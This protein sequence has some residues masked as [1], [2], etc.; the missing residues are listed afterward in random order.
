MRN[1][2]SANGVE[3]SLL[4]NYRL[5]QKI[6]EGGYGLVF[7]AEQ[8]STGQKVA[9]KM[10]KLANDVSDQ[11]KKQSF[12]R[13]ER[14]T[15]LCAE[16][17]HPHI[18][19]LLD[20]G[21]T[22]E[23]EPFAVFEYVEGITLKE[24][25]DERGGLAARETGELMGQVL[26]AI[27]AAHGKGIVHRDLKPH[28]I[29]VSQ[30][31]SSAHIKVLDF[32]IGAFT[33]EFRRNDYQSLTLTREVMGTPAYSAPEQLRGEPATVKS[34]LYAWGLI[35]LEC[36]TGEPVMSGDSVAEIFQ[37]QLHAS[38]VPL[39]PA[40][41]GHPLADLLRRVVMK[42]SRER[43]GE[44]MAI[45]K[46]FKGIN[47]STLVGKISKLGVVP[48][49]ENNVTAAYP[50]GWHDRRSEKRQITVLCIKLNLLQLESATLDM[51]TLDAIQKD[52]LN[53]CRDIG[54]RFGG[55][56]A[57]ALAD[58]VMVYFGYPQVSDN[59]ARRAGRTALEL[60]T[61]IRRR[62][63]LLRAQHGLELI[64]RMGMHSG[65]VLT[66]PNRSPEGRVPNTAL[67]LLYSA[68]PGTILISDASRKLLDPY[69]EFEE[70]DAISSAGFSIPPTC[71]TITGE[72]QTEAL[73][74]LRPWSANRE[75]IGRDRDKGNI[76][77][78]WETTCKGKGQAV[79]LHGQA[80]IGKSKMVYE[81]KKQVRNEGYLF[82]ECRCLPEH[83][84]NALYP[85]LEMLRN[86]WGIAE[87]KNETAMVSQLEAQLGQAG[88]NVEEGLPILCSWL[89]VPLGSNYAV[90]QATPDV[91][92][93]IL[94][95]LLRQ[96]ILH[97]GKTK[98][99]MLVLE[100]LHWL[101]PTGQEFVASLLQEMKD[102]SCLLLMTTR[103]TFVPEW[104]GKH[105]YNL[106]LETL[107]EASTKAMVE[108]VLEGKTIESAS[109][110][111]INK[112]ADGIPLYIEELTRMLADDG[113][114]ILK[115]GVYHLDENAE[116]EDIPMTLQ[117]LL[118][119]RLDRLG[120]TKE[121][122]QLAATMGREFN[123][124]LL[125][126][127]SLRDEALVQS[128]L[129]ALMNLDMVYRQRRVSDDV[130]VFR[131]ALIRDA[132]YEGMV[133]AVRK[134]HHLRVAETLE[135][136]FPKVV[137]DT[138]FELARHLA[139]GERFAEA[140]KFGIREVEKQVGKSANEEAIAMNGTLRE[141]VQKINNTS[142]MQ[143]RMVVLNTS[144][145]P[146]LMSNHGYA[147]DSIL[148]LN[149][150]SE[151]Y[152]EA[153]KN[154]NV[155][156]GHLADQTFRITYDAFTYH[157]NTGNR[158]K[159]AELRELL[160]DKLERNPDRKRKMGA[161]G[162][163]GQS[164]HLDGRIDEALK[165]HEWILLNYKEETDQNLAAEFGIDPKVCALM[166]RFQIGVSR[167]GP[168][169]SLKYALECYDHAHNNTSHDL[170]K[171]VSYTFLAIHHIY[172]GNYDEVAKLGKAYEKQFSN[173]G[174]KLWVNQHFEM[175]IKCAAR[176]LIF[177]EKYVE[178]MLSSGQKAF[179]SYFEPMLAKA[180]L[181]QAQPEKA[182]ELMRK[183][184]N[185]C[186]K[187]GENWTMPYLMLTLAKS[188]FV[189]QGEFSEEIKHILERA[190]AE[191]ER[192]KMDWWGL[193][194][195]L[196]IAECN[197]DRTSTEEIIRL[198][199][200]V[201]KV[202]EGFDTPT[203]LLANQLIS[204]PRLAAV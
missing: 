204:S 91:Q 8:L 35:T 171:D 10:L 52:Q 108:I 73:S 72:R 174:E 178:V 175:C 127:A 183:S 137:E 55:H 33:R 144:V 97:I 169:T 98:P 67:E 48:G 93:E 163:I 123:Y 112:R 90:S 64:P 96:S 21:Y 193:Q 110:S 29:M 54:A 25:I 151:N 95:K 125:V 156:L 126:R 191:T 23:N 199:S 82:R 77:E 185:R 139:G 121:T 44:A 69:L 45:H 133:G 161:Y 14:E 115:D 51:E 100:D 132:A 101:D 128:D 196:F 131:H 50:L 106:P 38:N 36:L 198:R 92:K 188:L 87:L 117:D 202:S 32:G 111:Y 42:N 177:P 7:E 119:A 76:L 201:E 141:W 164:L 30:I 149:Q 104:K 68:A 145:I 13:F 159:A 3:T 85:F 192:M 120:A 190:Y 86:H 173:R 135:A 200:S 184:I 70:A 148:K 84:N 79:I 168:E 53:L 134:E 176:D 41:A 142:L 2:S 34:D 24:L 94:F 105:L 150:E 181:D 83:Q 138:P 166:E 187:E 180:Y 140:S 37:Q 182:E 15:Q 158:R 160:L 189:Q 129:D 136:D 172:A 11:E 12:A 60:M 170:S 114:L 154:A 153:L 130:Y 1:Q 167:S 66:R 197:L 155:D 116:A 179:L 19:K 31:G 61:R 186:E 74:F 39:P 78:H 152:I 81:I 107:N 58:N 46:Q 9:I 124:E 22:T 5:I 16:L 65:V 102:Q 165:I 49:D 17:S 20:K 28:N 194:I 59:D 89:S 47:F 62:S 146:A 27:A 147:D 56:I 63:A 157:H 80:G 162:F 26:D 4:K 75:M 118:N 103:P 99:F 122:A 43:A 71:F 88:C 18:V 203:F 143:E 6:G 57:G 195:A 40:I 113:Y 109:F